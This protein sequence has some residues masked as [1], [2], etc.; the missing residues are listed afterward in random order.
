MT[1]AVT[2]GGNDTKKTEKGDMEK[3]L[4]S[5]RSSFLRESTI[6]MTRVQNCALKRHT[7]FPEATKASSSQ[8]SVV[9][10]RHAR[11]TQSPYPDEINQL[12]SVAKALPPSES[13]R[14]NQPFVFREPPHPPFWQVSPCPHPL[15]LLTSCLLS[16][17]IMHCSRL[18]T[19][20]PFSQL[21]DKVINCEIK[22][23]LPTP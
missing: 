14:Q 22:P 13:I 1:C 4:T 20:S 15:N 23:I 16:F 7:S 21:Q 3:M 18:S 9:K 2:R 11:F 8:K 5:V 19:N 10:L 17:N 6:I 12:T